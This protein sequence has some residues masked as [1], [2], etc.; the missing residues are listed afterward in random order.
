MSN[1]NSLSNGVIPKTASLKWLADR[2]GISEEYYN[3]VIGSYIQNDDLKVYV[4]YKGYAIENGYQYKNGFKS[5][6]DTGWGHE[7]LRWHAD[8]DNYPI[9]INTCLLKKERLGWY[10][11]NEHLIHKELEDLDNI[12]LKPNHNVTPYSLI[13]KSQKAFNAYKE[14][15]KIMP[16]YIEIKG[17][18][19]LGNS[20]WNIDYNDDLLFYELHEETRDETY[21]ILEKKGEKENSLFKVEFAPFKPETTWVYREHIKEFEQK[22]GIFDHGLNLTEQVEPKVKKSLPKNEQRIEYFKQYLEN[23]KISGL[24]KNEVWRA[25]RKE[26]ND[27]FKTGEDDFFKLVRKLELYSFPDERTKAVRGRKKT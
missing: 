21:Y 10:L 23:N 19:W 14:V 17:R 1:A 24:K 26:N 8:Y 25:M 6:A 18:V 3:E 20:G 2:W 4:L 11:E 13:E 7:K 12:R 16:H 22:M 15:S 27:L 5:P 9:G